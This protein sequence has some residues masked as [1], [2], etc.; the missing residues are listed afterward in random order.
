MTNLITIDLATFLKI[1]EANY[2]NDARA[3]A[4]ARKIISEANLRPSA[5]V[6]HT[7]TFADYCDHTETL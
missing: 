5:R 3:E 4:L 7:E 1:H 6:D 2:A